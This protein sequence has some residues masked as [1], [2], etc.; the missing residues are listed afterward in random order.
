MRRGDIQAR[1]DWM[2]AVDLSSRIYSCALVQP[3]AVTPRLLNHGRLR[4]CNTVA[5]AVPAFRV[6]Q[7]A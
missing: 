7:S 2:H 6:E 4:H 1:L 5:R 3:V